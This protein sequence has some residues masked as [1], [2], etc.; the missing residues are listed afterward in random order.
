[1]GGKAPTSG[2]GA[3]RVGCAKTQGRTGCEGQATS[4]MKRRGFL[5]TVAF[6]VLGA[7]RAQARQKFQSYSGPAVTQIVVHK[8]ARRMYLISGTEVLERY[9]IALGGNPLGPKQF[10]GDG[11]T[12]EGLYFIDRQNPESTYHLSLG[13]SYPNDADKEAAKAAG[14]EPGGDIFIHGRAKKNRGK[15]RD[16]TAGC[17]AVKDREMEEI[18]AM[19][20]LRTPIFLLP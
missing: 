18:Y 2:A 20:G 8:G 3:M 11:R 16:W 14:K 4:M 1:M 15:G 6:G 10:D 19:V 12:P 13:I 9:R 17:I 5:T 7:A